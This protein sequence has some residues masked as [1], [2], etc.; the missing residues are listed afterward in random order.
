M[1]KKDILKAIGIVLGI[2]VVLT[3]LIPTGTFSGTEVTKS[4]TEPIGLFD[5]I[6]Y[7]IQT[8]TTSIFALSALAILLIGGLYGVIN[9]TGVYTN[10]IEK[11]AKKFKGK[12]KN[13]LIITILVLGILSSLT[14][15]VL[16]LFILVPFF[17]AV[18]LTLGY[19]KITAMLSTVGAILVGSIGS[20]YGFNI[21]GYIIY[22]FQN[23]INDSIW[24]RL[25]LFAL[26]IIFFIVF[27][28]KTAKI[29][30]KT[31][32]KT[33]AKK[34]TKA[35]TKKKTEEKETKEELIIPLYEKNVD[36]KQKSTALIVIFGIMMLGI[37]VGMFNW[38]NVLGVKLFTDVYDAIT[39]FELNGYPI[40]AN[41][42]GNIDPMGYWTN[43]EFCILIVIAILL[44]KWA[45]SIKM[46]EAF[47]G[48]VSGVK[49]MVPVAIYV[50][51]A[52]ILFLIINSSSTGATIFVPI[53]DFFLSM[54]EKFNILT[55]GIASAVG[56]V[57]YNDFPYMLNALYEPI[58]TL[59][60]DYALVGIITQGIHGLVMLIAPTSVILIAG[61]KYFDVS[62][63]E[64]F[65]NIWKYLLVALIAVIIIITIMVLV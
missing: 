5:L 39:K 48:F 35:E 19:N 17:T 7:P 26:V 63:K 28:V 54:T 1:K 62:Y 65:K 34:T 21:N 40:F 55:F 20:T 18:I 50:F 64:W 27:I 36:K 52:N 42:L 15:L 46:N 43:T 56:S 2:Y 37:L 38:E 49:E 8:V 60:N 24:F 31:V 25:A 51:I 12:E 41:I 11:I 44:I 13:F 53:A 45:Y 47:E 58:N 29:E 30:R 4:A 14:G 61:L 33:T 16:P 32:K 59:T 3:W 22:F 9:K 10:L 6:K 57:I 23:K